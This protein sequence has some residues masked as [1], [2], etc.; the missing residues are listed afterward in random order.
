M[1][2]LVILHLFIINLNW[3]SF[4]TVELARDFK[5][6][7][8]ESQERLRN[9]QASSSASTETT[10]VVVIPQAHPRKGE[11][12]DVDDE[13]DEEED[14]D[15]DDDS[16]DDDDDDEEDTED[17]EDGDDAAAVIFSE[18]CTLLKKEGDKW[19]VSVLN[20]I[21]KF[22]IQPFSDLGVC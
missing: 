18:R 3:W 14:D 13:E 2:L 1:A 22:Y 15:D 7:F 9:L 11:D 10:A 4:Q 12:E 16:D 19:M 21:I 5:T 8:E 17:D 20:C 6:K